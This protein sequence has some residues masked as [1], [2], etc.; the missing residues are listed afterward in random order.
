[1]NKALEELILEFARRETAK[2]LSE[3]SKYYRKSRFHPDN[4]RL[5]K[6][7]LNF[8]AHK[9]KQE[10]EMALLKSQVMAVLQSIDEYPAPEIIVAD[11]KTNTQ[12]QIT[13]TKG[14]NLA[15][16]TAAKVL[17]GIA[18]QKKNIHALAV[19]ITALGIFPRVP[20]TSLVRA[21]VEIFE[22]R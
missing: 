9:S 19:Y 15:I 3:G 4:L 20:F 11:P 14:K 17:K 1:M 21:I 10:H 16:E 6:K 2:A 8:D 7:K 12:R 18:T 22:K 5:G 13:D